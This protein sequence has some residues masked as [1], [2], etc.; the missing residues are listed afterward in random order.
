[1]CYYIS[2]CV[3][4]SVLLFIFVCV[5]VYFSIFL[6]VL[7]YFCVSVSIFLCVYF[8]AEK[9]VCQSKK[10]KKLHKTLTLRKQP[11]YAL[12]ASRILH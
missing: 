8:S 3:L 1:M 9:K 6:C 2:V 12:G 10:K 4:V 11:Q 5:L 7:E